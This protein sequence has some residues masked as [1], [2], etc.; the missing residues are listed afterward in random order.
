MWTKILVV[1][2]GGAL[3]SV[4]RFLFSDFIYVILGR[5]F[6]YGILAVNILGCLAMGFLAIFMVQKLALSS[7]WSSAILVGVLGGFT[8]FS[9]FSLDSV[10]MMLEGQWGKSLLYIMASLILCLGATGVGGWI[11]ERVA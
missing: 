4:G 1:A 2:L 3:G 7:V 5:A 11:A 9:S 10:N 6:P 8:T